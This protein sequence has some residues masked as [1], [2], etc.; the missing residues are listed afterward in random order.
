MSLAVAT[1]STTFGA[2]STL[3]TIVTDTSGPKLTKFAIDTTW[4]PAGTV[5]NLSIQT[6]PNATTQYT[7]ELNITLSNAVTLYQSNTTGAMT[8]GSNVLTLTSAFTTELVVGQRVVVVGAGAS[9][10]NLDTWVTAVTDSTSYT[11]NSDAGTT[12]SSA[13]V[14]AGPTDNGLG[15][16]PLWESES[17]V[18]P[19]GLQVQAQIVSGTLPPLALGS[20]YTTVS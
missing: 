8:S 3:Y 1:E 7:E 2:L 12:V 5:L 14:Y 4:L 19:Y 15:S 9:G 20:Y 13:S 17:I 6:T 10:A 16:E 18:N 11:L